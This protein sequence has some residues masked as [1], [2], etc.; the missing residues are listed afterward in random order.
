[1]LKFN[2]AFLLERPPASTLL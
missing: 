2:F 1:M